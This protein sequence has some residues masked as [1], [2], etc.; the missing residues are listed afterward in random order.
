VTLPLGVT[1]QHGRQARARLI[2]DTVTI[3]RVTGQAWNPVTLTYTDTTTDVYTGPADV[4]PLAVG[5]AEVQA[6]EREVVIRSFDVV[7]PWTAADVDF[8][9]GDRVAVTASADTRLAG[10]TLTVV[11]VGRGGRR[12]ARHLAAED[13]D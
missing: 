2:R 11:G 7:L 13:R 6:G 8:H 10:R 1:L 3:A 12:L 9:V 5:A 4:K